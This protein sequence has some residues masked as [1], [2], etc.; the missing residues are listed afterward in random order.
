MC[1]V[2]ASINV[3]MYVRICNT[4]S[5]R[6]CKSACIRVDL[7]SKHVFAGSNAS[8]FLNI[9]EQLY[10]SIHIYSCDNACTHMHRFV[11]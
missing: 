8:V 6:R 10:S 2:L 11:Y 9:F 3:Y 5:I 7:H 1:Y 4:A